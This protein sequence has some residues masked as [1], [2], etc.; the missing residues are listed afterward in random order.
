MVRA[1]K[2]QLKMVVI[3]AKDRHGF[4]FA[5][6]P[7]SLDAAEVDE[8]LRELGID[9]IEVYE[10]SDWKTS[11]QNVATAFVPYPAMN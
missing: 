1:A 4:Y 11:K 10:L 8:N 9:P 5:L 2:S 6:V 7:A 3:H